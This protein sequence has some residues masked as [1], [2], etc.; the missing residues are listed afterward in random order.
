MIINY[1]RYSFKVDSV[2]IKIRQSITWKVCA[3]K[4]LLLPD[5]LTYTYNIW[6]NDLEHWFINQIWSW[7]CTNV[8]VGFCFQILIN[9]KQIVP[10]SCHRWPAWVDLGLHFVE[11]TFCTPL[12]ALEVGIIASEKMTKMRCKKKDVNE[13]LTKNIKEIK[14]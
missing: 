10:V 13:L 3:G 12:S 2:I 11:P 8:M 5:I 6:S 14:R 7:T 9:L 1:I 4:K